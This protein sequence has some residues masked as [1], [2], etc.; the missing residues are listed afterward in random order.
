MAEQLLFTASAG[1]ESARRLPDAPEGHRARRVHGH[2]FVATLRAAL[3]QGWGGFP[4]GEAG[5]LG[6][7]LAACTGPLD[8][9]LL[10]DSVENPTDENL[11]RWIRERVGV[12]GIEQVGIRSTRGG[13]A[14]LDRGGRAHAW[15]RYAFEAA[16]RLPRVPHGH[17]CGNMHGHSYEVVVHAA[18]TDA[19]RLDEC[20]APLRAQLH[21]ACLN[22][23]QGLENPTSELIAS[24]IWRRLESGLP[25]LSWV[26]VYETATCGAHYDGRR[27]GIWKEISLDSAIRLRRAPDGDRRRGVHGH[28][29]A[30][31]LHVGA[32]LD[33]LMGW[34]M[35]YGDVKEIFTPIFLRLDHR[36]LHEIEGLEDN[37]VAAVGGW[38]RDQ[39]RPLLP[40]LG[41]VDL[42]E[43]AGGAILSW[44]DEAPALPV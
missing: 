32:P 26:T 15:R 11:T 9:R 39:A 1:F 21:H 24:W 34:T 23:I 22:D 28:T 17:K 3:P 40:A 12:P 14:D 38:I 43:P 35:D 13:G 10:N 20:W 29:Y 31:R 27:Y 33:E 25:G 37:G 42:R 16:H 44:G 2:S 30:L 8:Y 19:A 36:P 18:R 6:E 7:K 5:A 4:G 41:R